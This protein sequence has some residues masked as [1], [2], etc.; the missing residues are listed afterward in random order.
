MLKQGIS[1]EYKQILKFK[2][3]NKFY[4]SNIFLRFWKALKWTKLASLPNSFSS[5]I[6]FTSSEAVYTIYSESVSSNKMQ[7]NKL[8]TIVEIS[9]DLKCIFSYYFYLIDVIY[10]FYLTKINLSTYFN[11][12]SQWFIPNVYTNCISQC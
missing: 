8:G 6:I 3:P 9:L 10:Y 4:G 7:L 5:W 11:S 12:I 2:K 1:N